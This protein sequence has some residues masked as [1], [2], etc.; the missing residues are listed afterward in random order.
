MTAIATAYPFATQDNKAIP[1][2]VIAPLA[3][4]SKAF[5]IQAAESFIIPAA[6][7]CCILIA[8]A[9]C[10][11]QISGD[12]LPDVLVDAQSYADVMYI[13]ANSAV[14]VVLKPGQAS[15]TGIADAGILYVQSIAKWDGLALEKQYTRK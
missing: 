9:P 4:L 12:T 3:L 13:P 14:S 2:D 8:T 5:E 6:Y 11:L 10:L 1:L 7:S 15:I